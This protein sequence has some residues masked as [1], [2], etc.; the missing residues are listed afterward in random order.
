LTDASS[1]H[2]ESVRTA[3]HVDVGGNQA[4]GSAGAGGFLSFTY[5]REYEGEVGEDEG[6]GL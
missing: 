3:L 4:K 5:G 1:G 6:T 2:D